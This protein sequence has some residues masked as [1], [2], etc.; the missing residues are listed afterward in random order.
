MGEVN[1]PSV[2]DLIEILGPQESKARIE[3]TIAL[4]S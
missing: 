1:G 2:H 3:K 4:L